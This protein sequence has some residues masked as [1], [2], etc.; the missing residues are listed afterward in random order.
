MMRGQAPRQKYFFL[1]P[2]LLCNRLYRVKRYIRSLCHASSLDN[3]HWGSRM[4]SC[5]SWHRRHHRDWLEWWMN[6]P[7]TAVVVTASVA[8][9]CC[10]RTNCIVTKVTT[11]CRPS[12]PSTPAFAKPPWQL[13]RQQ[14]SLACRLDHS[15]AS[16]YGNDVA[17]DHIFTV[18]TSSGRQ[19]RQS[20]P[21][22][23]ST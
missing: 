8:C 4:R 9:S 16:T 19:N 18:S 5:S 10:L 17:D 23:Y 7:T 2:P 11:A 13:T 22:L 21:F 14:S 12:Q 1:E 3:L 15:R 20:S 6:E